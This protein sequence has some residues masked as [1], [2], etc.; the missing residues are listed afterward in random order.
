MNAQQTG[1]DV[2][3][4]LLGA[5]MVFSM[6]G[7]FAFLEHDGTLAGDRRSRCAHPSHGTADF[8]TR[9][10]RVQTPGGRGARDPKV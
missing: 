1:S 2:L 7:G 3:F 6:H 4:V 8:G 5:I 10:A 9:P